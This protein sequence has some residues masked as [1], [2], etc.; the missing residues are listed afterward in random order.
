MK[1]S[2]IAI[3]AITAIYA[4]PA[5]AKRSSNQAVPE[6]VVAYVQLGQDISA[7]PDCASQDGA[8]KMC[9]FDIT[10]DRGHISYKPQFP[11]WVHM[12][13]VVT[14]NAGKIADVTVETKGMDVQEDLLKLLIAQYGKPKSIKRTIIENRMGAHFPKIEAS[15]AFKWGGVSF[16]G[17]SDNLDSGVL[18]GWLDQPTAHK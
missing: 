2:F 6:P 13:P 18:T 10:Q 17:I 12:A 5:L 8:E 7:Y 4:S 15:W 3:L 14:I 9:S 11:S 16:I 1:S